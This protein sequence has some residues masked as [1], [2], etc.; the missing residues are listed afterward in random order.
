[1]VKEGPVEGDASYVVGTSQGD[2][3]PDGLTGPVI[4]RATS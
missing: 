3:D 2:L 1:M 4:S